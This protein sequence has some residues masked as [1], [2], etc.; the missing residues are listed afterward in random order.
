MIICR[1]MNR[2]SN[3]NNKITMNKIANNDEIVM[4]KAI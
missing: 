1:N 2:Y 3:M 4:K